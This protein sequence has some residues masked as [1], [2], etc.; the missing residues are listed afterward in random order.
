V[1]A[2]VAPVLPIALRGQSQ[3]SQQLGSRP[4]APD[5]FMVGDLPYAVFGGALVGGALVALAAVGAFGPIRLAG[6]FGLTVFVPVVTFLTV[7]QFALIYSPRYLLFAAPLACVLG[8]LTLARLHW[9]GALA[10]VLIVALGTLREHDGARKSHESRG[11][12][13]FDYRKAAGII[14]ANEQPGDVI[15][16]RRDGWQFADIATEY[17]LRDRTPGDVL[18]AQSRDRAGSFWTPETTDPAA[19]LR[20]HHRVWALVPD[21][22]SPRRPG[23]L[24]PPTQTA[25][26]DGHP[27]AQRWRVSGIT[28]WLYQRT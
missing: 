7:S 23:T 25:V 14:G 9:A 17:Y 10:V 11:T 15:V 27:Q 4:V 24:Q 13:L 28:L 26:D 1:L 21:D 2:G 16:Y 19:A 20:G 12:P 18:A 6:V 5:I 8:G 22:L 3:L